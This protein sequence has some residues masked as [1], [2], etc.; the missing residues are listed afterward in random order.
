MKLRKRFAF[1]PIEW[2][3]CKH[4][5]LLAA[6]A[7]ERTWYVKGGARCGVRLLAH[8]ADD[9]RVYT[10]PHLHDEVLVESAHPELVRALFRRAANGTPIQR[11]EKPDVL[12][13]FRFPS[14]KHNIGE[15]GGPVYPVQ[16][17]SGGWHTRTERVLRLAPPWWAPDAQAFD[18]REG[19]Y[20]Y[21]P[22]G[23]SRLSSRRDYY[24]FAD[25]YEFKFRKVLTRQGDLL[26]LSGSVTNDIFEGWYGNTM[27]THP[28]G[29]VE[30]IDV[31]RHH[32]DTGEK[33]VT[34]PEHGTMPLPSETWLAIFEP[35]TSRPFAGARD[36]D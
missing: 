27:Q 23:T 17:H 25:D 18:I 8:F 33:V 1:D 36:T 32:I 4:I 26:F 12:P 19:V 14:W 15:E 28:V 2:T 34:H 29:G 31:G 16:V 7:D 20:L 22:D 30:I 9:D 11:V 5:Q 10:A 35:G 6:S 3:D 13:G 24:R 21:F